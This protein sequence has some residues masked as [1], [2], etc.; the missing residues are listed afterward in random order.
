VRLADDLDVGRGDMLADPEQPPTV[1]REL[2]ATVCWMAEKP[3]EPRAKLAIKQTTR[4]VRAVVDELVSVVDIHTLEDR[5]GPER[6][7]LND[8]AHVRLRLSEPLAVDS[9]ADNRVTG[10]FILVDESSNDTVAAGMVLAAS[11]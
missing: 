6:L 8:I 4:T 11:G 7:E 3:L 9:Y 2:E 10:A 5:P 1:A